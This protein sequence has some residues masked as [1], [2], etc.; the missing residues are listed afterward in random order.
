MDR[1]IYLALLLFAATVLTIWAFG[2]IL[3]PFLVPIAWAMCLATVTIGLYRKFERWTKR[4]RLAAFL[5]TLGTAL[6]VVLPL[7]VFGTLIVEQALS[8]SQAQREARAAAA[9][10]ARPGAAP[11]APTPSAVAPTPPAP[12]PAGPTASPVPPPPPPRPTPGTTSS[13]A[14]RGSRGCSSRSTAS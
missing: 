8:L 14:T 2:L 13:R 12:A 9:A 10:R 11:V 3:L 4:P 5:M 1:R 7:V 6:A